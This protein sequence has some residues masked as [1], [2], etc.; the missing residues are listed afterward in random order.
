MYRRM[1]TM[2]ITVVLI[3]SSPQHA[4][5]DELVLLFN[6]SAA[7]THLPGELNAPGYFIGN[8]RPVN[9]FYPIEQVLNDPQ[10]QNALKDRTFRV[11]TTTEVNAR[12]AELQNHIKALEK[13]LKDIADINDALTK[14]LD[15]LEAAAQTQPA[16]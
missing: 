7:G 14:R 11:Y 8:L 3:I 5:A 12:L 4:V 16:H 6:V 10:V 9:S 15:T 13:N 2:A 1:Q